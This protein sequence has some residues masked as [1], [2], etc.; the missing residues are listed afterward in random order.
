MSKH[1]I[2]EESWKRIRDILPPERGTKRRGRPAKD[3]RTMVNAVLWVL[4]TGSPWRDLPAE[5]GSWNSVYSRFRRWTE[6]GI[7]KEIFDKLSEDK[8]MKNIMTDGG[9]IRAYQNAEGAR[10]GRKNKLLASINPIEED[11]P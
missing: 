10:R 11:L 2:S 9:Y 3:N 7:W 8:D 1:K 5:Y 6:K 4:Q